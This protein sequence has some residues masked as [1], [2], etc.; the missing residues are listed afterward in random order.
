MKMR[1][2]DRALQLVCGILLLA[3][4]MLLL[5]FSAGALR[6]D[7]FSMDALF[8]EPWQWTPVFMAAGV[9]LIVLGFRLAFVSFG[10]KS[11]RYYAVQSG[12]SDHVRISIQAID[13]L[14]RK[15]LRRYTEIYLSHVN[16]EGQHDAIVIH[17]RMT[18]RSDVRIPEL[19]SE[20]RQ[21]VKGYIEECSGVKVERV[22]VMV[23]ATK[24]VDRQAEPEPLPAPKPLLPPTPEPAITPRE[25]TSRPD[26]LAHSEIPAPVMDWY[27]EDEAAPEAFDRPDAIAREES[28]LIR[29]AQESMFEDTR[30]PLF[31]SVDKTEEFSAPEAEPQRPNDETTPP[32][33]SAPFDPHDDELVSLDALETEIEDHDVDDESDGQTWEDA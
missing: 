2:F 1:W 22:E 4:G 17:L 11:G 21:D 12:D 10:S 9:L 24:D 5:L 3:L 32:G 19:V 28:A 30:D 8:T 18:I 7:A 27:P 14:T 25:V 26:A 33:I 13:H 15:C 23:E 16:I 29:E 20:I 31:I 6:F